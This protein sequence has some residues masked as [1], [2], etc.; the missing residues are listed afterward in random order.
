MLE[1]IKATSYLT[2]PLQ[3]WSV[4][5]NI[6]Y[7]TGTL[8]TPKAIV[9]AWMHSPG[10]RANILD[11]SFR[12]IGLG[13]RLGSPVGSDGATYVHNFGRRER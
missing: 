13:V 9:D 1:R 3:R 7:G 6:A 12:E 2:G 4:G 5:E 10:H 11:R 8:G